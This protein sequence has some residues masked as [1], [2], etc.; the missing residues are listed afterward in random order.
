M[1]TYKVPVTWREYGYVI[2]KADSI[3][4]AIQKAHDEDLPHDNSEY[5]EGSFEID[6]DAVRAI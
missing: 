6:Y 2:V 4:D 3:D 5:L 1:N